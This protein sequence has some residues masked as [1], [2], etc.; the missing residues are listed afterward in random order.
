MSGDPVRPVRIG[1]HFPHQSTKK[2]LAR[3][4]ACCTY[5][6]RE[7]ESVVEIASMAAFGYPAPWMVKVRSS[8]PSP[9]RARM[10]SV[11]VPPGMTPSESYSSVPSKYGGSC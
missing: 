11:W 6:P 2:A 9:S 10:S 5:R 4:L 8:Q 7:I 1:P 3:A